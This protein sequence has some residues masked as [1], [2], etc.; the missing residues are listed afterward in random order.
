MHMSLYLAVRSLG[1]Q[2]KSLFPSQRLQQKLVTESVRN[3]KFESIGNV[4][5]IAICGGLAFAISIILSWMLQPVPTVHDEFSYLLAGDT[6][7]FGRMANDRHPCWKHFESMHI[8]Q[9]PR[10]ASK[11]PPMQGLFL[12]VG[13]VL[14]NWPLAGVWLST[15]LAAGSICWVLQGWVPR[16]WALLGGLI[17][18]FHAGLQLDWGQSFM[19]GAPAVIGS[20]LLYGALPRWRRNRTASSGFAG[21]LGLAIL[22]NSRPFEGL[23]ISIPV[24][25]LV[26]KDFAGQLM[27]GGIGKYFRALVPGICVMTLTLAGMLLIN[28]GVTGNYFKL[29]YS[30]HSSQYMSGPLFVWQ[31]LPTAQPQHHN[32]VMKEFHTVWEVDAYTA[33]QSVGGFFRVKSEYFSVAAFVLMN[34]LLLIAVLIGIRAWWKFKRS[35]LNVIVAALC[36]LVAGVSSAVWVFPH[37]LAPGFPLL[38]IFAV[39]GIRDARISIRR[40]SHHGS[41][42]FQGFLLAYV[43]LFISQCALRVADDNDGW[44]SERARIITRL[45]QQPGKHLIIVQYAPQHSPHEE[46]VYNRADID[47]ASI[48]WARDLGVPENLTLLEHFSDRNIWTLRADTAPAM[49]VP[50]ETH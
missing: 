40:L 15:A 37:Y 7:A 20:A 43:V 45:E 13:Y 34:P 32:A 44:S 12:A 24:A 6:F 3:W 16:R 30:L 36:L 1:V 5:D 50:L 49:L 25:L 8:L 26:F 46:W 2:F 39:H 48:V 9:Q 41:R 47:A 31:S 38:L 29:P 27:I 21:A 28:Q 22:A 23:L 19:G 14:L 4:A 18:V 11:Y 35:E 17:A 10:Y 33:Q 42:I